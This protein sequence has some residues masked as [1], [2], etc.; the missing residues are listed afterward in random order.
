MKSVNVNIEEITTKLAMGLS[1]L[2]DAGPNAMEDM[3]KNEEDQVY[4]CFPADL[5]Y[6]DKAL[7]LC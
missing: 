6:Q 3:V 7:A 4:D 5:M 1:M 2:R